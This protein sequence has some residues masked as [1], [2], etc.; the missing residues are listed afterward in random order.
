MGGFVTRIYLSGHQSDV[1]KVVTIGSPYAGSAEMIA[2]GTRRSSFLSGP[3]QLLPTWQAVF[4]PAGNPIADNAG[5][6][7]NSW[8]QGNVWGAP[9]PDIAFYSTQYDTARTVTRHRV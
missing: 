6:G 9:Q 2:R 8:V 5:F 1:D 7:Y 3:G 4:D